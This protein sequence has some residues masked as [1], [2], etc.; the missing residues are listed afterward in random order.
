M[1]KNK[2]KR[3]EERWRAKRE[4]MAPPSGGIR[5]H[6]L[7]TG[8]RYNYSDQLKMIVPDDARST[9]Q[10]LISQRAE[11]IVTLNLSGAVF[12]MLR[13]AVVLSE[14]HVDTSDV[15]PTVEDLFN[16]PLYFSVDH[17]YKSAPRH[18]Q[19]QWVHDE[20][21]RGALGIIHPV[22]SY[23]LVARV[24]ELV[25]GQFDHREQHIWLSKHSKRVAHDY[26]GFQFYVMQWLWEGV[27]WPS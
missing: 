26:A 17:A 23:P 20:G 8:R 3:R 6:K 11:L 16:S 1:A 25:Q 24:D 15:P 10:R 19:G 12:S 27:G 21:S 18:L 5:A 9:R 4:S 22:D 7:K 13:S 2:A 14:V